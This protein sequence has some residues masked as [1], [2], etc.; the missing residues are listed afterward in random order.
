[1]S[2]EDPKPSELLPA[3]E[4]SVTSPFP[5][6][7]QPVAGMMAMRSVVLGGTFAVVEALWLAGSNVNFDTLVQHGVSKISIV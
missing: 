6:N 4:I 2:E 3:L 7:T 5:L 1:V